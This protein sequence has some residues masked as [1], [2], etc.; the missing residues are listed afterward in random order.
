MH[1]HFFNVH[2]CVFSFS[3]KTSHLEHFLNSQSLKG[4]HWYVAHLRLA[5]VTLIIILEWSIKTIMAFTKLNLNKNDGNN[6]RLTWY[7]MSNL[8]QNRREM[9]KHCIY[10]NVNQHHPPCNKFPEKFLFQLIIP[11]QNS[12]KHFLEKLYKRSTNANPHF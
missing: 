7:G 2:Y 5:R 8:S 10:L 6:L 9:I 11:S 3:L 4:N 12:R 1:R